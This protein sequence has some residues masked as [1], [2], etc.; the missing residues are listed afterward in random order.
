M[1]CTLFPGKIQ[2]DTRK[3]EI[4]SLDKWKL[5][6]YLSNLKIKITIPKIPLVGFRV[7]SGDVF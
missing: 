1:Q 7:T 5:S 2:T 3:K 4:F 6:I